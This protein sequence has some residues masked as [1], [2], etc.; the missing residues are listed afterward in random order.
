YRLYTDSDLEKLQQILFFRELDFGLQEIREI[1]D[2]LGFDRKRALVAH[3]ELL[4]EKKVRL[5]K[6]LA[7]VDLT[8]EHSEGGTPVKQKDMFESFDMKAIEEHKAKY[9]AEV[10]EKYGA[11]TVESEKRLPRVR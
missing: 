6:I 9:A 4:L 3:K 2:S 8:I 11:N 10:R 5:E 7:T 1:L